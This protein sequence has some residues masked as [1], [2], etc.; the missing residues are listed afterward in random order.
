MSESN[1]MQ[2]LM[3]DISRDMR[4]KTAVG[5]LLQ[6]SQL[7]M[8]ASLSLFAVAR[9]GQTLAGCAGL[10]GNIVKCVAVDDRWRGENLCAGLLSEIQNYA[11]SQGHLQLFLFT[12]P[13]NRRCFQQCGFWPIAQTDSV[14]LMENIPHGISRYCATL[15]QGLRAGE[16]IGSVV[17]NANPFTL[18]H[19]YLA[20]QA[21]ARCDWLHIFVVEENAALFSF[22]ERLTMVQQ[23]VSHLPNVTVHKGGPYIISRAT[24]PSYFLKASGKVEQAWCA[25]DLRI[26][27]QYIAPVLQITHRFV[28]SEPF[29]PVTRQYNQ[30]MQAYLSAPD[31]HLPA[32]QVV[33]MPRMTDAE[34]V[35]VSASEVRRLLLTQQYAAIAQRVPVSTFQHLQTNCAL[36]A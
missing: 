34:G 26:F 18:G 13:A 16:R 24:F 32:I 33:E 2:L 36:S 28:G 14:L 10:D 5:R 25:L 31:G 21:A 4:M 20:E 3:V 22:D 27:R 1:V 19:R 17:M 30:A 8:D 11:M 9:C 12:H 15:S 23:G 35:A 6:A 29:C 7:E